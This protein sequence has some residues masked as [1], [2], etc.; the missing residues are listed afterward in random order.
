MVGRLAAVGGGGRGIAETIA[1]D[2]GVPL[3]AEVLVDLAVA[4]VVDLVARFHR[5][6]IHQRVGVVAVIG[7]GD[8][9][10]GRRVAVVVAGTE[11]VAVAIRI[12]EDVGR[13]VRAG[14]ASVV[15]GV[16]ARVVAALLVGVGAAGEEQGEHE[17]A[18][19]AQGWG[20][21]AGNISPAASPNRKFSVPSGLRG[22]GGRRRSA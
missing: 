6:G 19:V 3:G 1:I 14:H 17:H 8:G 2:V 15:A 11:A 12:L 22:G 21:H 10:G 7:V 9:V 16:A 18:G 4:V 5:R 20:G 13:E